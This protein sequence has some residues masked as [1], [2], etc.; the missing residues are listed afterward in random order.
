MIR[1]YLTIAW[2]N[3]WKNKTFSAINI[4]G[5]ALGLTCSIFIF[6]WV[7]DEYS[8]DSF[9]KNGDRIY[10]VVGRE[11]ADN[12]INGSYDSPGILGEEL[13]KVMP[14]VEFACNYGWGN[15]HTFSSGEKIMKIDGNFAGMDFFK[16]FS[17]PLLQ[18]TPEAAL[19]T[20]ES[21]AISQ[22]MATNFFGSDSAA[23]N[24]TL[25]FENYKDLK[26]TAVFADLP[27]NV[28]ERF[29]YM[30]NWELFMERQPW[31]KDWDNSGPTT[32]VQLKK[33]ADPALVDSKL[34]HFIKK[35]NKKYTEL[36][37]L[38]LGLQRYDEK[39]LH[40]N[41]KDGYV[42][43]GRIEYVRLFSIVAV[44]ILLIACINFM[45]LSTARSLKRAKEI[46]VRKVIGAVRSALIRQFLSEAVLFTLFAVIIS[47]ALIGLLLPLFNALTGKQIITPFNDSGFWISIAALTLVTGFIAG[48]Y[49]ALLLSSFKP[50]AVLKSNLRLSPASGWFRKGLVVFQFVLSIVFIVGMIIISNQVNYIQTKNLGYHKNNLIYIPIS[51]KLAE[52]FDLFK[53]EMLNLP[54]IKEVTKMSNRPVQIE[55]STGGVEWE[56]KSPDT[57]PN[58]T[59]AAVGYDFVKTMEVKMLMGRDFSKDFADS[60]N[61]IINETALKKIGYKDPIGKPLTFWE[62]KG[63][64]VGVVKDFHFNSL[65]VP[66]QPLIIRLSPRNSWGTI[67]IRTEAGKTQIALAGLEKLHQ[68]FNPDFPFSHQFA[69]EEYSYLYKSEQVVQRLSRYFA[70]LAIFISCLGLLGLVLFTAEQ[71]I[72]EIGIRK[73]LGASVPS[74]FFLLSKD[75]L[76]LVILAFLIGAPLAWWA[77]NNWLQNYEYRVPVHWSVFAIACICSVAIALLT[78]SFQAIKAAIAN[79]VKSL[80]SE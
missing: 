19:K 23:I 22:K 62:K 29:E 31:V 73:V 39:Y 4:S 75:F 72:R 69:D 21:I 18:G 42:S 32:F 1:N 46:G 13:K 74:L 60:A 77:M 20:P 36:S 28:S 6:L 38:E 58:F 34:Q 59:Q 54:G 8:V 16:I 35:Y 71:R 47:I 2:R 78:I 9:H 63:T 67:L 80:R 50:I 76:K 11:Y 44:F 61:Y 30:I 26:V 41:F 79:P 12:Q 7:R 55:N 70:F 24:K 48:S 43:G 64:I 27:V 65:H 3:L 10:T 14:E 52:N 45:N 56:G 15:Y 37:R 17:Y 66:I 53:N 33:G 57:K 68:K 5:L 49:P 51:G 40:S 25:R